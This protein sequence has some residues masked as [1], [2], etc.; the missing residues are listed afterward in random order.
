M[1]IRD[2]APSPCTVP[3][4]VEIPDRP[5][6]TADRK[7]PMNTDLDKYLGNKTVSKFARRLIEK[8][9]STNRAKACL[10]S[11][12]GDSLLD[13][14]TLHP[15]SY[16]FMGSDGEMSAG[17]TIIGK[18]ALNELTMVL[19]NPTHV[20]RTVKFWVLFTTIAVMNGIGLLFSIWVKILALRL[21]SEASVTKYGLVATP[22]L[23]FS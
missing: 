10:R 22:S 19:V 12:K 6:S 23:I 21:H 17:G 20:L 1:P 16:T 2:R 13:T 4:V 11:P 9:K 14:P 8:V 5:N 3:L 15:N 18:S 7:P